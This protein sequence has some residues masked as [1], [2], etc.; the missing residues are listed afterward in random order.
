V[1]NQ[2]DVTTALGVRNR[3]ILETLYSSGSR[4]L[5]LVH[6]KLYEINL[7]HGTLTVRSGKGA[8]D[9]VVPIS[10]RACAW[11]NAPNLSQ[12]AERRDGQGSDVRFP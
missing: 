4:R 11:V 9:R 1:I 6:L 10:E 7:Q 3:A 5:E 8:K 2:C 12:L